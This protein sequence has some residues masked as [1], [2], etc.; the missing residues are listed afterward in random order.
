MFADALFTTNHLPSVRISS[1]AQYNTG[2]FI[3]DLDKVPWGCGKVTILYVGE[4]WFLS[5]IP[6][7]RVARLLVRVHL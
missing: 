6:P 1:Q 5:T 7:S 3:L 4:I 2:L